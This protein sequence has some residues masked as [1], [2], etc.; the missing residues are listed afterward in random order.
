M[1]TLK[2]ITLLF[3]TIVPVFGIPGLVVVALMHRIARIKIIQ[4]CDA[5]SNGSLNISRENIRAALRLRDAL[6]TNRDVCRLYEALFSSKPLA[7]EEVWGIKERM[8]NLHRSGIER[9][10]ESDWGKAIIF[11]FIIFI[12]LTKI[13]SFR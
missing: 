5:Y 7:P 4:S 9:M 10:A 2:S 8:Q 12:I 13:Y 6:R 3:L 11:L 1:D